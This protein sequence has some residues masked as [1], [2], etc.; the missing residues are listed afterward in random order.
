MSAGGAWLTRRDAAKLLGVS[1][2][3]LWRWMVNGAI[4]RASLLQTGSRYRYAR[5][6][7]TGGGA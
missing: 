7:C 4:P 6:W 5:A 1:P 3:T 2:T